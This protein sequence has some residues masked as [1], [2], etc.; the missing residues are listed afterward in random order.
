MR[1]IKTATISG[2]KRVERGAQVRYEVWG[3]DTGYT[4]R[5]GTVVDIES[6][7]KSGTYLWIE[8]LY[9]GKHLNRV[10]SCVHSCRCELV[11]G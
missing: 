3:H 5:T 2:R 1:Y 11:E 4:Y 8:S 7:G 9:G 6:R 10:T